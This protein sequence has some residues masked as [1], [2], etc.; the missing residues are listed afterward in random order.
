M[1][2]NE[3]IHKLFSWR[4][5]T[6]RAGEG[7]PLAALVVKDGESNRNRR[8]N[9]LHGGLLIPRISRGCRQTSACGVRHSNVPDV[10]FTVAVRAVSYVPGAIYWSQARTHVSSPAPPLRPQIVV[11]RRFLHQG[12]N[13][14][15]FSNRVPMSNWFTAR[16]APL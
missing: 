9:R 7:G 4:P 3:F 12:P 2:R 1:D 11:L 10:R 6:W 8:V 16:L 15:P 14:L 13:L 5:R